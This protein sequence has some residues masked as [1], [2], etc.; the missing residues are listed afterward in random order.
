MVAQSD[1][2]PMMIATG[3]AAIGLM[4]PRFGPMGSEKKR[5]II[6][7][8]LAV[9]SR[10]GSVMQ[11]FRVIPVRWLLTFRSVSRQSLLSERQNQNR[12]GTIELLVSLCFR[13]SHEGGP[14]RDASV[15]SGTLV[16]R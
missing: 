1:W 7:M 15:G 8:D 3:L 11:G 16:G 10:S 2:L 13:R 12:T 5:G 6:G 14:Q 4:L 9:A